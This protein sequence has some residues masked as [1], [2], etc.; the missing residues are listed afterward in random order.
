MVSAG[1]RILTPELES[2]REDMVR[3]EEESKEGAEYCD[4]VMSR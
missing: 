3:D 2:P 1:N 4:E